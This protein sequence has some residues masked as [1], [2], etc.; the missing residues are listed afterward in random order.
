MKHRRIYLPKMQSK[1]RMTRRA[2]TLTAG[3]RPD[4]ANLVRVLVS[5]APVGAGGD[6]W[7]AYDAAK[8]SISRACGLDAPDERY[9]QREYDKAI[10]AYV[11]SVEI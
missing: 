9:D 1:W 6:A 4:V 2:L 5:F 10:A 7:S 8:G 3:L 11:G